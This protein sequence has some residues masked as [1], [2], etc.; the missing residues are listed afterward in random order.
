VL[1]LHPISVW[2]WQATGRLPK[3]IKLGPRK[4]AWRASDL[5]AWLDLKEQESQ[6]RT[7]RERDAA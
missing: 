6:Q 1:G 4:T 7:A 2:K 3:P 5:A